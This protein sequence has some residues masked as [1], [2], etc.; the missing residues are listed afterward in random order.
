MRL[1]SC[2]LET[3]TMTSLKVEVGAPLARY[4]KESDILAVSSETPRDWPDGV[5][6]DGNIVFDLDAQRALANF[7]VHIG[8]GLWKRGAV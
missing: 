8:R 4:D 2:T 5:D 7:D 1:G 6:V 3:W